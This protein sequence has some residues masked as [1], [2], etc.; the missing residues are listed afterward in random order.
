M[1]PFE[2]IDLIGVDVNFAVAR[3]FYEQSFGEPRWRP[4]PIQARMVAAGRLGR[5][6]GRGF[7]S[8]EGERHRE[9]DPEVEARSPALRRGESRSG[10]PGRAP[11]RSSA[12]SAPRS[13]TRPA[14]RSA[15]GSPPPRTSTRRCGWASTGRSGR[16]SGASGWAGPAPSARSRSCAR[17]TARPTARRWSFAGSAPATPSS[18]RG[19]RALAQ[20]AKRRGSRRDRLQSRARAEGRR[21]DADG[22]GHSVAAAGLRACR[23]RAAGGRAG[24][25]PTGTNDYGGFR[26]ILPPGQGQTLTPTERLAFLAAGRCPRTTTTSCGMYEDLVYATPGLARGRRSTSSS[27]TA[28]SGCRPAR[29]ERTYSPAAAGVTVVR[30]AASACR[31]S[32]ATRART[33]CSAPATSA[34]RTGSS[35]WTCCATPGRAQLSSFA[36]GANKAMDAE[37]LGRR[38][39]HRGGPA[40]PDRP[41]RRG[42]RRRGRRSSSRTW[43]TTSPGS[44]ST[45]SEARLD[46]TQDAGRVR[47]DPASRC[48]RLEG[49]RRDRHRLAGR[50][51]LRQGRRRR[52]RATPR[53]T[54]RAQDRFGDG[55]GDGGLGGLPPAPTTPRRRRPS[56]HDASRTRTARHDQP[57]RGRDPGSGLARRPASRRRRRQRRPRSAEH[58]RPG[59]GCLPGNSNALLVSGQE[60]ASRP[61]ARRVRPAGRLLRAADPD[62]E[63]P[64]RARHRRRAAPPSP[65]S[66]STCCSGAARTTPGRRPRRARTSST[67][68]P[69]SSASPAAV[70]ARPINSMHYLYKGEC[71]PIEVLRTTRSNNRSRRTRP[72]PAPPETYTLEAQRTVHGIVSKRGTVGGK[73]G[74]LR[75]AALDLLPRGRLGARLLRRSTSPRKVSERAGLPAG[76]W[77]KINFTF[78]WFYAD[79]RD[80]AYFNSGDNPVRAPG[81]DPEFP[82]WGTGRVGLAGLRP[83]PTRRTGPRAHTA[84]YARQHP[85]VINQDYLTSWNNKQA[86]GYRAAEASTA[87]GSIYRSAARSTTGSSA[88]RRRREDD[89]ARADRR[90]GG[91]RHR[92]PA[93]R[94]G[95]ALDARRDRPARRRP[96]D[97]ADEVRDA[98]RLGRTA[99]PTAATATTS[100]TYDDERAV[101]LMD[102]WWTR[103]ATVDRGRSSR[104][105]SRRVPPSLGDDLFKIRSQLAYDN[106]P[107]NHGA[108][109]GSAYQDGWWGQFEKD[110]RAILGEPVAGRPLAPVLRRARPEAREGNARDLPRGDRASTPSFT[111]TRRHLR[112]RRR[113][114]VLDEVRFRTGGVGVDPI[115]WIN[116][117]TW[118]QVVRDPRQ[119]RGEVSAADAQRDR[120]LAAPLR[121]QDGPD[122]GFVV[123]QLAPNCHS[124]RRGWTILGGWARPPRAAWKRT[125]AVDGS[126]SASCRTAEAR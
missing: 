14:S 11:R 105:R 91:R 88:D 96:A 56:R 78:N 54:A 22:V 39:L 38:A 20:P 60:S 120:R 116:R 13:P 72:I 47:G 41:R 7:Y 104:P 45:S 68:S 57:G 63:G 59:S 110:L 17:P 89:P 80:I 62:G 115:H 28:A 74:R 12:A 5:K 40:A 16:S 126:D 48:R 87:T 42:L 123:A 26:N 100:G 31:T 35:S 69:R 70:D 21:S 122:L 10:S 114:D 1:G 106:P 85:Q 103:R 53:S 94:P 98:A 24:R 3:S 30:D 86:P 112:D 119:G 125:V 37:H 8:Y 55:A 58:P 15:S 19:Q 65:G 64:A 6:T 95:A 50:R 84:G 52:G 93:R 111:A 107:N 113:P 71:R 121:L 67:P 29:R 77:T 25:S 76:R 49:H 117:P 90:D 27:R 51:H 61:P 33:S 2:L 9:P 4:H 82:T 101:Q 118:Q 81:T 102:A 34:P 36:G 66:T 124:R 32:T 23:A 18:W 109:L 92:R 79:D 46:P 44:T 99:A 83:G 75:E 73:P 108:H 97:L 43:P